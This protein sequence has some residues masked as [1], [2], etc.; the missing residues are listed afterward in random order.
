KDRA[1]VMRV[2][3]Q[4]PHKH[5][6][7]DID[8]IGSARELGPELE[9]AAEE[10]ERRREL[11]ET[12]VATLVERGLFR[13]LLP[14]SLGGAELRPAVYVEA[15]EEVAKHDAS[16]AWCLGRAWGCSMTA[17]YLAPELAREIFGGR[18]G[19]VAWGPPGP[20]EARAVPGGYRLSGTWS[21]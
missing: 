16:I 19:I 14:R 1:L 17:A 13:L 15:M 7:T 12:I 18:R 20:A 8:Y 21:F 3:S 11:P 5:E 4:H 9:A 6:T 10:I 2:A